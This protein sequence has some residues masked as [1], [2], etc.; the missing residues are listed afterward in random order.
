MRLRPF[1]KTSTGL[2]LVAFAL[3]FSVSVSCRQQAESKIEASLT[4][5]PALT[6]QQAE[7]AAE[8]GTEASLALMKSLGGQLKAA[9]QSGGPENALHVCQ[10]VAQPLTASTSQDLPAATVTRTALMVRNP[11]NAPGTDDQEVLSR[12]QTLL[13]EGQSLPENEIVR[14]GANQALFYKPILT[15]AICLKC[16]GDPSTFSPA[17][18]A[19]ISEAYPDDQAIGF[20]EGDL[21]GVFRVEVSLP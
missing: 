14:H 20:K 12:W 11:A 19:K 3:V 4:D 2:Y 17:L 8:I 9:L 15:E 7:A 10:Q 13:A 6:T 16:H 21:R 5:P 18:A 1:N